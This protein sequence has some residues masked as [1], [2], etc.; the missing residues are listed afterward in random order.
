MVQSMTNT[1]SFPNPSPPLATVTATIAALEATQSAAQACTHGAVTLRNEKRTA[2]IS[3]LEQ[4]KTHV[5]TAADG[6]LE[7]G[8]V[9]HGER[10][11]NVRRATVRRT[12]PSVWITSEDVPS[13][14]PVRG[15]DHLTD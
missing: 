5:Q 9:D 14:S 15:L 3:L 4:L 7:A 2:L 10:R 6:N 12:I 13:L 11:V 8:G 1:P